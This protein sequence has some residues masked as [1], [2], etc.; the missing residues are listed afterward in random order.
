V[1]I[2][3]ELLIAETCSRFDEQMPE[4]PDL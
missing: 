2:D 3:E 1:I 4:S